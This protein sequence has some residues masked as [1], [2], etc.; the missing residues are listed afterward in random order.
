MDMTVIKKIQKIL[1]KL[2]LKYPESIKLYQMSLE[3][4]VDS[5]DDAKK[6]L[7]NKSEKFK[8]WENNILR[9]N[10]YRDSL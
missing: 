8:V 6:L 2:S 5:V 9:Y 10:F 7:A 3:L 1:E 4:K